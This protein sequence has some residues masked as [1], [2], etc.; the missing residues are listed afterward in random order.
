MEYKISNYI[1]LKG[2]KKLLNDLTGD[3]IHMNQDQFQVYKLICSQQEI[4]KELGGIFDEMVQMGIIVPKL[5][6][7]ISKY[8]ILKL[9]IDVNT[10]CNASCVYC[11]QSTHKRGVKIMPY[12]LFT[13]IIDKFDSYDLKWV[14]LHIYGE[15]LLDPL[16]RKRVE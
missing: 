3:L 2:H 8:N 10:H 14:A 13:Q 6:D 16:Y 15:P 5:Q 4:P 12:D 7:E 11:P 9:D 1:Y